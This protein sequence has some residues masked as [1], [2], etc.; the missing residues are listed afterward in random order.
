SSVSVTGNVAPHHGAADDGGQ[1][2]EVEERRGIEFERVLV[3]GGEVGSRTGRERALAAGEAG[4]ERGAGRV[5]AQRVRGREPLG[6]EPAAG[7]LALEVLPGDGGEQ[8][9]PRVHGL[10][11]G[12]GAEGEHR[13]ALV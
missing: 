1:T 11:G 5:G 13:A 4:G 10:H 6:R 2:A 9:A 12:I 7:G 3:P 8:A